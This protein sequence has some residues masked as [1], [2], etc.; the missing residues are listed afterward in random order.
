MRNASSPPRAGFF[1]P[2]GTSFD[3]EVNLRSAATALALKLH[4]LRVNE[5]FFFANRLLKQHPKFVRADMMASLPIV[6]HLSQPLGSQPVQLR[7]GAHHLY[8]PGDPMST[9]EVKASSSPLMAALYLGDI[10]D[11]PSQT[12]DVVTKVPVAP[13]DGPA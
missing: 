10:T 3:Q 1:V 8:R 9:P 2:I 11:T 6:H 4:E 12:A 13:K 5:E 7:K